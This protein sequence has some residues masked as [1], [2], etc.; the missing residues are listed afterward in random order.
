MPP[1]PGTTAV[2]AASHE[3]SFPMGALPGYTGRAARTHRSAAENLG[4]G[5]VE[6]ACDES[7]YASDK[8]IGGSTTALAQARV[9][10][11]PWPTAGCLPQPRPPS[12]SS[13]TASQA[14]PS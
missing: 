7:G 9:G 4:R 1:G 2:P 12:P 8:L 3:M 10:L 5:S 14:H 11:A 6:A 13:A